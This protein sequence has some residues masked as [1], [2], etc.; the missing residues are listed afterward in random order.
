MRSDQIFVDLNSISP[1]G[2]HEIGEIVGAT[3]ASFVEG[4]ILGAISVFG[5][6]TRI[7]LG[8]ARADEIAQLL[9]ASGL[10]AQPFGATIGRASTFKLLRS[11]F[12]KS[13]ESAL[14]E[15]L[16]ASELAGMRDEM[17]S[18]LVSTFSSH[19]FD[20]LANSWITTHPAAHRRRLAEMADVLSLVKQQGIT[21]HVAEGVLAFFEQSHTLAFANAREPESWTVAEV[22]RAMAQQLKNKVLSPTS[23]TDQIETKPACR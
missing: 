2:K 22:V 13:I 23:P 20:C 21:P 11:I 8:G 7:L 15:T 17:W 4:V 10:R 18:E 6:R 5:A 14:L 9:N 3:G 19:S 12:S 16:I 1:S